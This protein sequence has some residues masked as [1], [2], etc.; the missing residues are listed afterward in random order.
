METF[1]ETAKVNMIIM[2]KVKN[3]V[4]ISLYCNKELYFLEKKVS[5]HGK[6]YDFIHWFHFNTS[7][8]LSIHF[9]WFDASFKKKS[10]KHILVFLI[11]NDQVNQ[12]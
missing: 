2:I 5:K 1:Y 12:Y 3:L 10:L 4:F 11:M 6:L 8:W 9:N 7:F